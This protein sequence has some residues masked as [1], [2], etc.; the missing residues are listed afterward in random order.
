MRLPLGVIMTLKHG[1]DLQLCD[2]CGRY[3]YLPD[4]VQNPPATESLD[5]KPV[6]A[7]RRRKKTL[8]EIEP[9]AMGGGLTPPVRQRIN[10]G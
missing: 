9:V 10:P 1:H 2:S 4:E 3:L 8:P 6:R 7:A 5:A